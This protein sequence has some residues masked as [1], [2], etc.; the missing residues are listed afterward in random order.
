MNYFDRRG[1]PIDLMAWAKLFE[2]RDYQRV[3]WEILSNGRLVS[4]VW[5]GLDHRFGP[6]VPIIFESMVFALPGRKAL[7]SRRYSSETAALASH[8]ELT[9]I[10]RMRPNRRVKKRVLLKWQHSDG[11]ARRRQAKAASA[12][13]RAM[14]ELPRLSS[15]R[16]PWAAK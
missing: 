16:S 5:L 9:R 10:W 6:G 7:D 13:S 8:R 4:T 1:E 14:T 12:L 2:Q 3:A 15:W 11:G